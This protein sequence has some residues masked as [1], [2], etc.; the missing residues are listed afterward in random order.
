MEIVRRVGGW[1]TLQSQLFEGPKGPKHKLYPRNF[2]LE[3]SVLG[4]VIA[5]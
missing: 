3:I 2:K 4:G 5:H 1:L